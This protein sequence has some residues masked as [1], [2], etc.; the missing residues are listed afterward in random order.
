MNAFLRNQLKLNFK[1]KN[2]LDFVLKLYWFY[3]FLHNHLDVSI[4]VHIGLDHLH[5]QTKSQSVH[6]LS[7]LFFDTA[8]LPVHLNNNKKGILLLDIYGL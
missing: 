7:W 1:R 5:V 8:G 4:N 6:I 2:L 3:Q